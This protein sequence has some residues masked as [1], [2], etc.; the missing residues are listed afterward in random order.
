M[1][2]Q[3][4]PAPPLTPHELAKIPKSYF[5]M[6]PASWPPQPDQTLY[7]WQAAPFITDHSAR[8]I[9]Y[10]PNLGRWLVLIDEQHYELWRIQKDFDT[11]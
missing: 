8:L 2:T 10:F 4:L 5:W 9:R 1:Q 3:T 6:R 11:C 7:Y